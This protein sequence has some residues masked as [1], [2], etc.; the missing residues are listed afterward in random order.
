MVYQHLTRS[1]RNDVCDFV[2]NF[3]VYDYV[4]DTKHIHLILHSDRYQNRLTKNERDAGTKHTC[5]TGTS[6]TV[7]NTTYTQHDHTP[8]P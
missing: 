2:V 3:V 4:S 8:G 6:G 5:D 7:A 1:M